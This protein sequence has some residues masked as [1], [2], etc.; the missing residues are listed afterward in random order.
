[1]LTGH[2]LDEHLRESRSLQPSPYIDFFDIR[3]NPTV[4][5]TRLF[6][7]SH[8][9]ITWNGQQ[10]TNFPIELSGADL[11]T[12]G[13]LVRPQLKLGNPQG[14]FSYAISANQIYSGTVRRYRV[15]RHHLDAGVVS[16]LTNFWDIGKVASLNRDYLVLEL[17]SPMDRHDY[18]LPARQFF[19]PEFPYV[20][21]N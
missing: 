14:V 19:P 15:L 8:P 5:A 6:L 18:T 11:K 16:Y 12:G 4:E 20:K 1:M 10:W 13:E 3:V 17:R 7:T 21:L 2:N 9:D